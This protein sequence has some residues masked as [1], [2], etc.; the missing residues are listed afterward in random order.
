MTRIKASSRQIVF[1]VDDDSAICEG[2]C[3]LLDSVGIAAQSFSTA[4]EFLAAWNPGLG[5]CL[6]LDVRLPGLNGMELQ[7][8]L[9][10][11]NPTIPIIIMTGHGDIPM[12][13]KALK[14]GAAEFL[15]KP[16]GDDELLDAIELIFVDQQK[17]QQ[18]LD[19]V[20]SI[21]ARLQLLTSRE[22][23]VMEL[24]TAGHTNKE[25]AEKLFLSIVTIKMHRGHLMR[26]MQ[27][28]SVADLVRMADMVKGRN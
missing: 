4:E 5:G 2:L 16:F 19:L 1:I 20:N 25:I 18:R 11:A 17:R 7:E 22:R 27:A 23:E 9:I 10:R 21:S 14:S 3:D 15:V 12:V 24:V 6:L 8:K 26:K 13:R 28:E